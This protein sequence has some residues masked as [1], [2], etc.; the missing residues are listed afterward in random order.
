MGPSGRVPRVRRLGPLCRHLVGAACAT[1]ALV[2]GVVAHAPAASARN[3]ISLFAGTYRAFGFS[4]DG[5]PA[6]SAKL[7]DPIGVVADAHGDV[8]IADSEN[9][10]V[11]EVTPAGIITTV[12]GTGTAGFSGD[13][14]SA[15]GA[16]A[17]LSVCAG[18]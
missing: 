1:A 3:Q 11:R 9:N 14:G 6:T 17:E 2:A 13:G 12:A 16:G 7:N 18:R 4:G 5:G 8:Y 15:A 10:R